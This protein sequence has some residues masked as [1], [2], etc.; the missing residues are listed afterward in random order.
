MAESIALLGFAVTL[1]MGLPGAWV[2]FSVFSFVAVVAAR[3]RV[4]R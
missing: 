3:P 4:Q 2:P 1:V